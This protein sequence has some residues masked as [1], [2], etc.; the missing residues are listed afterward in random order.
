[1][2]GCWLQVVAALEAE[3][4][5]AAEARRYACPARCIPQICAASLHSAPAII[6]A[7][8]RQILEAMPC[9]ERKTTAVWDAI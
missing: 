8:M 6:C 1:M 9:G 5:A 4:R 3:A 7:I 2:S